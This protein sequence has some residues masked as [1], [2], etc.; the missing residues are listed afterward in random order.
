MRTQVC[1]TVV[2]NAI[3]VETFVTEL[4]GMSMS[5]RKGAALA[6]A[7]LVARSSEEDVARSERHQASESASES[8]EDSEEDE[9]EEDREEDDSEDE[10]EDIEDYGEH[11]AS[12]DETRFIAG[13][14]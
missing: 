11:N 9:W 10:G 6:E 2:H 12:G 3:D 7:T 1:D 8:E 13:S 4:R 14:C 5:L